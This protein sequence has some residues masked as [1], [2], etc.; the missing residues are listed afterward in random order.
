M[1]KKITKIINMITMI[2]I[3]T[4]IINDRDFAPL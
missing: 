2:I 3:M 1:I 4:T